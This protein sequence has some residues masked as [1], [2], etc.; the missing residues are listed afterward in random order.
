MAKI[1]YVIVGNSN[2]L[3]DAEYR[4]YLFG[5]IQEYESK[6][7]LADTITINFEENINPNPN[8]PNLN[9]LT[10][11][12]DGKDIK[13]VFKTSR[14]FQSKGVISKP[15]AAE[16][17]NGFKYYMENIVLFGDKERFEQLNNNQE[18]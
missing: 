3:R 11:S 8:V 14:F 17:F 1:E 10:I 4:T 6:F 5:I 12:D 2:F 16:F 13:L 15:S 7:L 9:Q 18:D